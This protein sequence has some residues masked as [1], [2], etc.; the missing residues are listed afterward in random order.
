MKSVWVITTEW[1]AAAVFDWDNFGSEL[2]GG[3]GGRLGCLGAS[4]AVERY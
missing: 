4:R 2:G 3:R 1:N